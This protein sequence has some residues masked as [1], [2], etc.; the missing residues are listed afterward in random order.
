MYRLCTDFGIVPSSNQV[1]LDF[2]LEVLLT[3]VRDPSSTDF[4][5]TWPTHDE[6]EESAALLEKIAS[7]AIY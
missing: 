7:T 2:G 6:I 3:I 1:Y 4:A 5:V